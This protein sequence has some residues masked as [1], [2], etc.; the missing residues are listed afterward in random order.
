MVVHCIRASVPTGCSNY[1]PKR[2][3]AQ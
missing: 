2:Y 1:I 3:H